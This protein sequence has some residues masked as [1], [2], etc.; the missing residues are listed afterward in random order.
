MSNLNLNAWQMSRRQMLRG[1]GATVTEVEAPFVPEGGAYGE[2]RVMGHS[3]G[4]PDPLG[5]A[6]VGHDPL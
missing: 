6:G 5:L 3:H 2:G 4:A 1:L